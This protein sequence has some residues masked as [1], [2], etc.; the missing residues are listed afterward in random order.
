[1]LSALHS[2][3]ATLLWQGLNA[4]ICRTGG[5]VQVQM[6]KAALLLMNDLSPHP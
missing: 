2:L 1:M 5:A 6:Y 3:F 4:A